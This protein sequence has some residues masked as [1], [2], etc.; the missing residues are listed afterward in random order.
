MITIRLLPVLSA[1]LAFGLSVA[2]RGADPAEQ[3]TFAEDRDADRRTVEGR[4]LIEAVDGG[5]LLEDRQGV[6]WAITPDRLQDRLP[7]GRPFE[8]LDRDALAQA[9][10]QEAGSGF[11]IVG[12]RHYV[13]CTSADKAYA[14]WV[15]SLFERLLRGFLQ[16]WRQA[17]WELEEP[18]RPLPALVFRT[19][20]EYAA[21]ATQDAGPELA[22]KAGYYSIRTNRIVLYD[23]ASAAHGAAGRTAADIERRV[24]AA[25]ANIATIIHEA[26]HQIAFNCGMHTRYADTPMWVAEGIAMYC[27]TPDLRTGTGWR[28]IG[29]PNVQRLRRFRDFAAGRR[30]DDSL[31]TLVR[32]DARFRDPNSSL[33]AY[34]ESW[35][36]VDFLIRTRRDEFVAYLRAI[37]AKPR[38]RWDSADERLAD[39]TTAFGAP[40]ALEPEFAQSVRRLRAR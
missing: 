26:A 11:Q 19:Q 23:L 4:V 33:D 24:A 6:L 1:L 35:A 29:R 32:D 34:A 20:Q 30:R 17:G 40:D 15:G 2:A 7:T 31:S 22:D 18:S 27:E 13:L 28:T 3:V 5:L 38:L 12:T 16:F 8:P 21:Y 39:F 37:S 10:Q 9:L 14:E 36:L 25:P